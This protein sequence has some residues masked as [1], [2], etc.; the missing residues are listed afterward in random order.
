MFC[1]IYIHI[2][3]YM[4]HIPQ[5]FVYYPLRCW[6]IV[7][8]KSS[9]YIHGKIPNISMNIFWMQESKIP[10]QGIIAYNAQAVMAADARSFDE[11]SPHARGLCMHM[12]IMYI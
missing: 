7:T 6:Y 4:N 11:W 1:I 10:N 5:Y 12:P 9:N 3:F 8:A 2:Y